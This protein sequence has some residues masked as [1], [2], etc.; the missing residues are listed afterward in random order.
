MKPPTELAYIFEREGISNWV[1]LGFPLPPGG[2]FEILKA[3][4]K[5]LRKQTSLLDKLFQ[6]TP[7]KLEILISFLEIQ[8]LT[9]LE[10]LFVLL[11]E[12][13][14]HGLEVLQILTYTLFMKMKSRPK[15]CSEKEFIPAV[16][17]DHFERDQNGVITGLNA[18]ILLENCHQVLDA[19]KRLDEIQDKL[20]GLPVP[21]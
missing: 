3:E 18:E 19:W 4:D 6:I 10:R 14:I 20:I 17:K 11:L 1:R 2:A 16:V 21:G 15:N 13:S 9:P 12:S 8:R 5:E 7:K